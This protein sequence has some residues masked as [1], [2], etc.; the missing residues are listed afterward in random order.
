M[1]FFEIGAALRDVLVN[2][3]AVAAKV[4]NKIYSDTL[5]Q[6]PALPSIVFYEMDDSPT[7]DISGNAGLFRATVQF[8]A[9]AAKRGAACELGELVRLALQGYQGESKGVTIEGIYLLAG[10]SDVTPEVS[11]RRYILTFGVWY[12]RANP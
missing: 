1:S 5:P 6:P 4:G 11:D 3:S 7:D 9:V 8:E 10:R 12:R 2:D